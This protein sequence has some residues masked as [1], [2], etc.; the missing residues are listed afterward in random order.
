VFIFDGDCAFCS[1]C[2]RFLERHIPT[3][4]SVQAWQHSD[5]AAL[6][7]TQ[8]ECEAAVQW[9]RPGDHRSGPAAIA[10]LLKDSRG[11]WRAAG[12]ALGT[13]PALAAAA[14]VYRWISRNRHRMPGGSPV[15]A[16]PAA[17]RE[18]AARGDHAT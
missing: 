5:L 4:A 1:S 9:V 10:A 17:Q 3:T 18:A 16:L 7:V 2:A 8:A 12:L 11:L 14:P 15:C 6:G 13:R